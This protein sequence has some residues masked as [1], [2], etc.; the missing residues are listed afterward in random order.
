MNL[1]SEPAAQPFAV[2]VYC[3][4]RPGADPAYAAAAQA[5]GGR[6]GQRGWSLVY[7]GGNVGLMGIVAD[8]ALK[9]GARAIGVIPRALME[10]EVGHQRLTEQH[11]VDNMHQRKQMMAERADAFVALPGGIGTL[12]ELYEVWT[13]YQLGYHRKPIGLLN[14]NGYYDQL[15]GFMRHSVQQGFLGQEQLDMVDVDTDA[16]VLLERL[17]AR[18]SKTSSA[19]GSA[20]YSRI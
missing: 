13:W 11:V 7:G 10:R 9:A 14:V 1:P 6:I 8:A 12:E 17:Y 15:L 2:C 4:S 18:A 5:V 3:G 16:A 20:D 19:D